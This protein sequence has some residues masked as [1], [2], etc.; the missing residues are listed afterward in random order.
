M[1]PVVHGG[2]RACLCSG[3]RRVEVGS[4]AAWDALQDIMP[5]RQLIEYDGRDNSTV[6]QSRLFSK[7][8]KIGI[9][10]SSQNHTRPARSLARLGTHSAGAVCRAAEIQFRVRYRSGFRFRSSG[11]IR[12]ATATN[13]KATTTVMAMPDTWL[14]LTD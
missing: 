13:P 7:G 14:E 2:N 8:P 6:L 5:T 12:A 10:D 4:G 1:I 3:P 9:V 11:I